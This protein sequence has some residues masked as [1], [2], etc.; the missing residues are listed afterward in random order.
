MKS[1]F[2]FFFRKLREREL[3]RE[4]II[5]WKV[6]EFRFFFLSW[7]LEVILFESR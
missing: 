3:L 7:G 5:K 4:L 6:F 1:S 2:C